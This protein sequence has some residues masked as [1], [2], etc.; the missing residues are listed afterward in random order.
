MT[1]RI[2]QYVRLLLIVGM[3]CAC[4]DNRLTSAMGLSGELQVKNNTSRDANL[5]RKE[6]G[7]EVWGPIKI[8]KAGNDKQ[9][10]LDAGCYELHAVDARGVGWQSTAYV[11]DGMKVTVYIDWGE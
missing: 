11:R 2:V 5:Q 1:Q 4:G 10:S 7:S 3:L 9:W 8:V 6:C